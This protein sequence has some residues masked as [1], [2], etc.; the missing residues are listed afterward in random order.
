MAVYLGVKFV[1]DLEACLYFASCKKVQKTALYKKASAE[2]VATITEVFFQLQ[3]IN[4]V[5]AAELKKSGIEILDCDEAVYLRTEALSALLLA[6]SNAPL[7][8]VEQDK[9]VL[10]ALVS[11]AQNG[12]LPKCVLVTGDPGTHRASMN[13]LCNAL[14]MNAIQVDGAFA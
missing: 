6:S 1:L 3:Q 10:I 7:G 8:R 14:Q 4:K 5:F 2:R 9:L 12:Q 13:S 11:C